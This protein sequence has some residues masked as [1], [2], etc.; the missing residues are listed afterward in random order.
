MSI[1][2][3]NTGLSYSGSK[4]WYTFLPYPAFLIFPVYLFPLGVIPGYTQGALFVMPRGPYIV[5]GTRL[6]LASCKASALLLYYLLVHLFSSSEWIFQNF[7]TKIKSAIY[8]IILPYGTYLNS[9]I[10]E[11][12]DTFTYYLNCRSTNTI[13]SY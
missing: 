9:S 3:S 5:L 2:S 4:L 10:P 8:S 11:L 12:I 13:Q 7:K 6:G 1:I